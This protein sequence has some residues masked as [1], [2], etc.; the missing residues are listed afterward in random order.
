MLVVSSQSPACI[1]LHVWE[2]DLI[3]LVQLRDQQI[4]WHLLQAKQNCTHSIEFRS[5]S[6]SRYFQH[7]LVSLQW[8]ASWHKVRVEECRLTNPRPNQEEAC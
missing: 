2:N 6:R 5:R 4:P 8:W 3:C 7:F 1:S